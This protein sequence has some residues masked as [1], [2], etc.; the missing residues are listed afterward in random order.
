MI[1]K[2]L[3]VLT[4]VSFMVVITSGQLSAQDIQK[5][6]KLYNEKKYSEAYT[7]FEKL[8]KTDPNNIDAF[9]GM[10]WSKFQI[11]RVEEAER[12][13]KDI[14]RKSPYHAGASEGLAAVGIKRYEN[15]N[16]AWAQYYAGD[17]KNAVKSFDA[18]VQDKQGLLPEKEM[19]RVYLGLGYSHSGNKEYKEARE[20]FKGSLKLQDN[21]DAHKGIGLIEFENKNFSAAI[22]SFKQSLKLNPVQYDVQSLLSWGYFRANRNDEA[23]D[24]FKKQTVISPYDADAHYGLALALNKKGDRKSA[25]IEFYAAINI[26]PGYVA[27][28]EFLKTIRGAKEYKELYPYLGWSLYHAGLFKNSL[29]VFESGI[30]EYSSDDDLLRGAGY[31]ALKLGKYNEAIE[32]SKKS[33]SINPN[34]M[35]VYETSF[36]QETGFPYRLYSDA[37]T[38]L[39]WSYLYKNDYTKAEESFL[40]AIKT[41]PDWPDANSGLAWVY[42]SQK[43]YN[44]AE[45]QFNKAIKVDPT[46]ADA[47]SG[48]SAVANA[49]LGKSG[50]G[51]R[52][53]YTGQS[54]KAKEFFVNLLKEQNLSPEAR[55]SATRGLGWSSLMLKNYDDAEKYFGSILKDN[56]NDYDAILGIG[57]VSY[58][59]NN[60]NEAIKYLKNAV[61][62]FPYDANAEITLGWSY[63]KRKD[64]ANSL[65][66]FRRAVQ[67]NPYI[68]E[69]YRG[70]GFSLIKI[71]RVD[72]GKASLTSA[73]NIYPQGVNNDELA[74]LIKEKKELNDL[75]ITIAWSYYNYGRFDDAVSAVDTIRKNSIKYADADMLEGYI[76]Y[77]KKNY[78]NAIKLFTQYL[79][80]SPKTEKGFGKYS[81]AVLTLASAYYNKQDYDMAIQTFKKLQELHKDDDIWAAPYD[82]MGWSYLKKG[83]KVEAEKFFNKSLQLAPGY[84]SSLDGLNELKKGK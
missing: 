70:V 53:Y 61:K 82:G 73:I 26:L 60:F 40:T 58:N 11:G 46:Y 34:L 52:F 83:S 32:Y 30:R 45:E 16:K 7:E 10:A 66:E 2:I 51:W 72:E 80:S 48:L 24:G 42:Y 8:Y 67:L 81:E 5:A 19:W 33:L 21:Y 50:D 35:P 6:G 57:Y 22:E 41:H 29:L 79:S 54:D 28:E 62:A 36:A 49:R 27:A 47:Y 69:P 31:A 74:A 20:A 75:Y 39:A 9:N 18:V 14:I 4:V 3:V 17:F 68:A 63:Y 71:G 59:R 43:K 56:S 64:Y 12:M 23:I 1:R 44:D 78:D 55:L 65:I 77:K 84:V 13:F 15:F 38:T 37:Q 25:L 76:H